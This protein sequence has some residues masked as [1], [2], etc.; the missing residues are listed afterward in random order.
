[1][2]TLAQQFEQYGAWRSSVRDAVDHFQ[3]WLKDQDL[4]DGQ[5][6]FR[7]QRIRNYIREDKLNV[8]FVAEFSRG[9]SELINAIF[10]ADYGRRILPSSAGRTTMCPTELKY[11]ANLRPCIRLLPIETRSL[12]ASTIDFRDTE[13]HWHIIP[14]DPSSAEGMLDAFQHVVETTNVTK[15]VAKEYGLFD[16]NDPNQ[17]SSV[18]ADGLVEISKW[19]HAI[20]NFPHPLLK[21]GLVILDTPGLNAVGT[22][23]ELTLR[24]I[25]DAHVVV[26]V[27]SAD[28]G[29]TK[30]DLELWR[31][32]INGNHRKGCLAVLNKIDSMWDALK[33]EREVDQEIARQVVTS[34]HLLGVDVDH[35]FPLSA[36]KGLLA[37]VTHDDTLLAKS[38]LLDFERVLTDELIPQRRKIVG[39]QVEKGVREIASITQALVASRRRSIVEQLFELRGLRGKNHTVVKHMLKRVQGEKI[40]FDQ[41]I[42]KFQA[43]RVVLSRQSTL[44]LKNSE[45]KQVKKIIRA[46]K[47]TMQSKM[48]STGIREEMHTLFDRIFAI[49]ERLKLDLSEVQL[50]MQAMT[51][52]FNAENGFSLNSPPVFVSRRYEAALADIQKMADQQLSAMHLLTQNKPTV[53]KK[54]FSSVASRIQET[55]AEMNRDTE[56]WLKGVLAP[57]ES[58]VK[59]H[60][61]QLKRRLESIERIHTATETLED[62]IA[63][64]ET[65]LS[66]LEARNATIDNF[67]TRVTQGGAKAQE[68]LAA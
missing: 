53:L 25:P 45:L 60:Q 33:T 23:P 24:L 9:K 49:V 15:E 2:E 20:I 19:R 40:E 17:D 6:E 57:L 36:Q 67:V 34:A 22:E 48:F 62:R 55:F 8:A 21:D 38:R 68:S 3:S 26:F 54:F 14:L 66:K 50:M 27:L 12:D 43:L 51:K 61:Q 28:A 63:E 35:V 42:M 64:L 11:D 30:S 37:K 16:E 18:G 39:D 10:F 4:S 29:V 13:D 1:M 5:V 44:A 58:Q 31:N 56:I 41:S 52:R 32:H 7:A 59:E 47:E 46:T 65:A